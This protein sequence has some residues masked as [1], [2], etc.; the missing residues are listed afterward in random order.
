MNEAI[1]PTLALSSVQMELH[2]VK[3][4]LDAFRWRKSASAA[5]ENRRGILALRKWFAVL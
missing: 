5:L 2:T 4:E 1:T 3:T